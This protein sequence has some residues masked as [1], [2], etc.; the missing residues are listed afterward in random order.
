MSVTRCPRGGVFSPLQW[1][2]VVDEILARLND[3]GFTTEGY[4]DDFCL[5][6]ITHNA[7]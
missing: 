5:I 4:A 1:S 3:A 2:R 6:I 7:L